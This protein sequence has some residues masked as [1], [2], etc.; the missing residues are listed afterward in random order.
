MSDMRQAVGAL[1]YGFSPELE[2][3]YQVHIAGHRRIGL[4]FFFTGLT[5]ACFLLSQAY[6][7]DTGLVAMTGMFIVLF[8]T[9]L[10]SHLLTIFCKYVVPATGVVYICITLSIMAMSNND[11]RSSLTRMYSLASVFCFCCP[12][13]SAAMLPPWWT[14]GGLSIIFL[15]LMVM[16]HHTTVDECMQW[17][18]WFWAWIM[19]TGVTSIMFCA[20]LI[21]ECRVAF[22]RCLLTQHQESVIGK[23]ILQA[24]EQ[25]A[26]MSLRAAQATKAAAAAERYH[27]VRHVCC[28]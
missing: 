16:V 9:R 1:W 2:D 27:T 3:A 22:L 20:Y 6:Q 13:T 15:A 19:I 7:A 28:C 24:R 26:A 17:D 23:G 18:D 10:S 4:V 21:L 12:I 5:G 11:G 25:T 14:M 8:R